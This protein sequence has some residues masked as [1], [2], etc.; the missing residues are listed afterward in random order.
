MCSK[1][2]ARMLFLTVCLACAL[3]GATGHH[4]EPHAAER[5]P[6]GNW[7]T[8]VTAMART[9]STGFTLRA[10][11]GSYTVSGMDCGFTFATG[12]SM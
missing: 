12:T 10:S 7:L 3:T 9:T 6:Q 1:C 5:Q 11:G 8:R 2:G 4:G